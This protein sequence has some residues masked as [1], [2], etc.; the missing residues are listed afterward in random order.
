M[1]ASAQDHGLTL[2]LCEPAFHTDGS[3]RDVYVPG[4]SEADWNVFLN[5]AAAWECAYFVDGVAREVPKSAALVFDGTDTAKLL[6]IL[7]DGASVNCHFFCLEEIELD[8]DPKEITTEAAFDALVEY[9][10]GL[11]RALGKRLVLTE[12]NSPSSVWLAY[13]PDKDALVWQG[14]RP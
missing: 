13:D 4:T 6:K 2:T 10:L 9:L 12:E 5:H 3:L 14:S 7:L 8:V 1:A 11:G